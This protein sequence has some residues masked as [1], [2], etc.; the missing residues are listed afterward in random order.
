MSHGA[1]GERLEG[2]AAGVDAEGNPLVAQLLRDELVQP[3]LH[4]HQT[5]NRMTVPVQND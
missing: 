5:K 2:S 3:L 1:G 4:L